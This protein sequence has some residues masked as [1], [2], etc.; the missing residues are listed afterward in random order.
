MSGSYN[1]VALDWLFL[2]QPTDISGSGV[3]AVFLSDRSGIMTLT[4]N[5]NLLLFDGLIS[6]WS[7]PLSSAGL[8]VQLNVYTAVTIDRYVTPNRI[9][10]SNGGSIIRIF[11]D[12]I[13]GSLTLDSF[14]TKILPP[15]V[16]A[17]VFKDWTIGTYMWQLTGFSNTFPQYPNAVF[18]QISN[19]DG[20]NW[21]LLVFDTK[22]MSIIGV[23]IL[24]SALE[25]EQ[26]GNIVQM[27]DLFPNGSGYI[28]KKGLL[29]TPVFSPLY[30]IT[31]YVT[32]NNEGL[33]GYSMDAISQNVIIQ[34]GF[35]PGGAV[36]A[37]IP[38]K[39]EQ[40]IITDASLYD[41]LAA[42]AF[43][44]GAALSATPYPNNTS[45]FEFVLPGGINLAPIALTNPN[46]PFVTS[47]TAQAMILAG[48]PY[49]INFDGHVNSV[50]MGAWSL[51]FVLSSVS[52]H[53]TYNMTRG[54]AK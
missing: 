32:G 15:Y 4:S 9:A 17:P 21:G 20:V 34:W 7:K 11:Y 28:R 50:P 6:K 29:I 2:G 45:Q 51:D 5:N 33:T 40:A 52:F 27:T 23:I 24:S 46:N 43:D 18:I 3:G 22:T 48:K 13:T 1:Q 41:A 53:K 42:H 14:N 54:T 44:S 26:S 36:P 16:F 37:S 47:T 10:L 8:A 31:Q 12:P 19:Q 30:I 38:T 35:Q 49:L 39:E 25:H